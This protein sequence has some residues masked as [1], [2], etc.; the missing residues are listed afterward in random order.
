M[1]GFN[2]YQWMDNLPSLDQSIWCRTYCIHERKNSR[3]ILLNTILGTNT[4]TYINSMRSESFNGLTNII[5]VDS[6]SQKP[7]MFA[8]DWR[9]LKLIPIKS[10]TTAN[11]CQSIK[12]KKKRRLMLTWAGINVI[13]LIKNRKKMRY[14]LNL[15]TV[16]QPE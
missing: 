15:I 7:A 3:W 14:T 2:C 6:P 13:F 5:R 16:Q 11:I 4:T 9:W 12:L 1:S 10:F 8:F